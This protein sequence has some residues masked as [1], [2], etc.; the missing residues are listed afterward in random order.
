MD[1]KMSRVMLTRDLATARECTLPGR[2][3]VSNGHQFVEACEWNSKR[4]MAL[5]ELTAVIAFEDKI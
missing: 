3:G 1:L 5:E 2:T 4:T